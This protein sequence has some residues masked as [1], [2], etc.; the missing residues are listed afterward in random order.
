MLNGQGYYD[1]SC[2]NSSTNHNQSLPVA[3]NGACPRDC[4]VKKI[5]FLV[6]LFVLSLCESAC[7]TPM[8]ILLLR[9]VDKRLAPF[10]LGVARMAN[11]L[12]AYIPTP[13]VMARFIDETCVLWNVGC[14]GDHGTCLE[15]EVKSLHLYLFGIG[16]GV[17]V[18]SCVFQIVFSVHIHRS[19]IM[20]RTF[21]DA[22]ELD[23]DLGSIMRPEQ[24]YRIDD[25]VSRNFN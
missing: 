17:K 21:R 24:K 23:Q 13:M 9:L 5:I 12:M 4:D 18:L 19:F 16:L 20:Q 10:S 15:Y 22:I 6:M 8:T 2:I 3:N 25:V 1:C 7:L 14:V 11:I